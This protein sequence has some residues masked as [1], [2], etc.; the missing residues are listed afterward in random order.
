MLMPAGVLIVLVLASIAVDMALVQL[1]QR[2]AYDLAAA[3]ANDAV[4]AGADP[5][6]L[7]RGEYRLDADAAESVVATAVQ[8]SELAGSLAAPPTVDIT[9]EGLVVTISMTADYV[10]A[11]VIPGTPDGTTV[12]ATA[13]ATAEDGTP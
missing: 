9:A 1:R 4:T 10:F 3:A 6:A 5:V 13:T 7:R 2:Q 12:T 8:A 11:G